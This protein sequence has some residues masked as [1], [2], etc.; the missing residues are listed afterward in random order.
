MLRQIS[1]S[2]LFFKVDES[3]LRAIINNAMVEPKRY[4]VL[5]KDTHFLGIK[6]TEK[7]TN[8]I[9]YIKHLLAYQCAKILAESI[10]AHITEDKSFTNDLENKAF[11]FLGENTKGNAIALPEDSLFDGFDKKL[12]GQLHSYG[13]SPSIA[14]QNGYDY[15]DRTIFYLLV[16]LP[17]S[18]HRSG[19]LTIA[20][21]K[22]K[23]KTIKKIL[24]LPQKK[25]EYCIQ[26]I[27]ESGVSSFIK[28]LKGF[29]FKY[30]Q[31]L[32]LTASPEELTAVALDIFDSNRTLETLKSDE[33]LLNKTEKFINTANAAFYDKN[34]FGSL[35]NFMARL[36]YIDFSNSE[37]A[38]TVV[39]DILTEKKAYAN[40]TRLY[41]GK[42]SDDNER[43]KYIKEQVRVLNQIPL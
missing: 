13:F 41:E 2:K 30:E 14:V 31:L 17:I 33:N 7:D 43:I 40:L 9:F 19:Y 1:T 8:E 26:D 6:S 15:P 25:E 18:S 28:K 35:I 32:E 39:N 22:F 36:H 20:K 21:Y 29:I 24:Q 4:K 23:E 10:S 42:N 38:P 5:H 12:I 37:I 27:K 11:I 3:P 16:E 34:S